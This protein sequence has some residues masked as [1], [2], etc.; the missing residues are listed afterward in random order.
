MIEIKTETIETLEKNF[1]AKEKECNERLAN[2]INEEQQ[3][4]MKLEHEK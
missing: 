4:L 2:C 1:E 3:K